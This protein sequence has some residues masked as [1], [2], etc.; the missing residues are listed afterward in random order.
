MRK[1]VKKIVDKFLILSL[2][3]LLIL[4]AI[5]GFSLLRKKNFQP[6]PQTETLTPVTS[7]TTA[8]TAKPSVATKA[9][10][11]IEGSLSY[12][13]EEIPE[14]LKICT[15]NLTTENEYC[16]SKHVPGAEYEYGLGY[17]L[18]VPPGKYHVYAFLPENP[19]LKAYYS[20]FVTCGLSVDCP[21]HEP[22]KVVVKQDQ[23]TKG[24]DPGDWY[25][26][27]AEDN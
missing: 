7:P 18:E 14:T 2:I 12:P 9:Y 5:I 26:F 3:V 22:I 6:K 10:G 15:I 4:V 17:K 8:P 20:E 24:V 21:S 13:S 23:I 27:D 19:K 16:T 11:V 1:V 25:D